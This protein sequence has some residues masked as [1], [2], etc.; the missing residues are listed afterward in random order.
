[1]N[2]DTSFVNFREPCYNIFKGCILGLGVKIWST[3]FLLCTVYTEDTLLGKVYTGPDCEMPENS[4]VFLIKR[5]LSYFKFLSLTQ[6]QLAQMTEQ[7]KTPSKLRAQAFPPT[8]NIKN[9]RVWTDLSYIYRFSKGQPSR[10]F[11]F[12]PADLTLSP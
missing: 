8:Q 1:M 11:N 5:I 4:D 3:Y 6:Q 7:D 2:L 10:S 12:M 9:D